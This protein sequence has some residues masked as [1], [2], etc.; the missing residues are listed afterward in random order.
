MYK[1]TLW[2]AGK[3]MIRGKILANYLGKNEKTIYNSKTN[4]RVKC[5]TKRSSKYNKLEVS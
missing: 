4:C 2:Y 1:V 3:E 5:S